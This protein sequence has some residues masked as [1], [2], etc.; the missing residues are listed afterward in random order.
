MTRERRNE[1]DLI[2]AVSTVWI[3]LFH[4]SFAFVQYSVGGEHIYVMSHANGTWGALFVALFFMLSGASLYYNWGGRLTSL[5]GKGGVLD[6]YKKRWLAI[7]PMFYIAWFIC[8]IKNVIEFDRLWNWGGDVRLL[9]Y[10]FFGMDGYFM[11]RGINY[12]TVGEWFLG[13][14][15]MLYILYPLLQWCIKKTPYIATLVITLLFSL[16]VG[17]RLIPA[18]AA[19]NARVMISDNINLITCLMSFW[20]GMLLIKADREPVK[21]RYAIPAFIIGVLIMLIPMPVSTLILTPILSV[22]FYIVLSFIS[23][24]LDKLRGRRSLRVYD[25]IVGFFSRYSFAIF[26]VHH[27]TVQDMMELYAG[28]ELNYPMS[29]LYFL[30]CLALISLLA[31]ALTKLTNL[32]VT[33]ISGLLKKLSVR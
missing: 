1:F 18:L 3:V 4:Y 22:C 11:Y 19:Y 31:V 29:I 2:R 24:S 32:I 27:V 16:N 7:F 8:Y 25:G 6:F 26:L 15:I 12:Y 9:L 10:T 28:R 30:L 23:V 20:I 21:K 13:A 5:K 33:G 17:R 14:I